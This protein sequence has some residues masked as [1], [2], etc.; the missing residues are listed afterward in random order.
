MVSRR[1]PVDNYLANLPPGWKRLPLKRCVAIKI[2]DGPHETPELVDDG[3]PF[4]SA[5]SVRD[6]KIDFDRRRGNISLALHRHYIRKCHPR[7]DD[8]LL[9]KSGATTGKAAI[10][11]V[12]FEFSVWSPLAQI[13]CDEEKATARFIFWA[14]HA[15]YLQ[16]Q[17]R[18][19][20][21]HGTQP[22]ISMK[23]IEQ[24]N[25][26]VPQLDEQRAIAGFLDRETAKIGEL[27]GK[28]EELVNLFYS[29]QRAQN[30]HL[31]SRG[32]EPKV[33]VENVINCWP[34]AIPQHWS[35]CALRWVVLSKC[36]GPFGSGLKNE[37]YSE[38]G[39]RVIR[40]QNIG[41]GIFCDED[42]AFIPID[43]YATL[44]DHTV[45]PGDLLIAGLGDVA[46]PV[47][48][49]CIAPPN[50]GNAMVKA[51]CFRFRLDQQTLNPEF[52]AHFLTAS[53]F[54]D[55]GKDSTGTTRMRVNLTSTGSR[56]IS[57]PSLDEQLRIV[58]AIQINHKRD[59]MIIDAIQ[60][61][62]RQLREYRAALISAA[63]TGQIDVRDYRTEGSCL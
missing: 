3:I 57:F 24:L 58:E 35:I 14:L 26:A 62:V 15:V 27:I 7:R 13:R 54:A 50:L 38:S 61:A 33:D 39:V 6:G 59:L 28:K 41:S 16:D 25:V 17:I 34:Y 56:R 49:A 9:C 53:A 23:A 12:D 11:D 44:G 40:L 31:V 8:I 29:R 4:V 36:D 32:L 22:N 47:G 10:V 63:V 2:T 5:E 1:T 60:R 48:R 43:Y 30:A 42:Q 46:H 45:I 21:S 51:D 55:A 18:T 19:T 52:A 37:H 20:W